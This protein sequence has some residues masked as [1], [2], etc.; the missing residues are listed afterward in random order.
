[1]NSGQLAKYSTTSGLKSYNFKN[2]N[3]KLNVM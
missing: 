3:V 1:M 2:E